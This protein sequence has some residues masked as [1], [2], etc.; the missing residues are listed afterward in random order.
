MK[1]Y[2]ATWVGGTQIFKNAPATE[3]WEKMPPNSKIYK[4]P[5]KR[6]KGENPNYQVYANGY[7]VKFVVEEDQNDTKQ[8]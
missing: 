1:T 3:L 5:F 2:T 6:K 4:G 7:G 8:S